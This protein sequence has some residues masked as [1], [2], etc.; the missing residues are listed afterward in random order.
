MR[1]VHLSSEARQR[2]GHL[3]GEADPAD[4]LRL[5]VIHIFRIILAGKTPPQKRKSPQL[6]CPRRRSEAGSPLKRIEQD[7]PHWSH[8]RL[9]Q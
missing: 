4:V 6:N 7:R 3:W 5:L 8:I 1:S 2:Q 9:C